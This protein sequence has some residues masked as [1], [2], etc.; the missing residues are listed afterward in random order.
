MK[1]SQIKETLFLET[2][3]GFIL[4]KS[5][6]IRVKSGMLDRTFP[7]LFAEWD[8]KNAFEILEIWSEGDVSFTGYLTLLSLLIVPFWISALVFL[9]LV[10]LQLKQ[11]N[12][13]YGIGL[14]SLMHL[15]SLQWMQ[16]IISILSISFLG[17]SGQFIDVAIAIVWFFML[18][19][20][21]VKQMV[22]WFAVRVFK[23]E[24]RQETFLY[25]V[26]M[27]EAIKRGIPVKSIE[28]MKIGL[29]EAIQKTK[30]N[31]SSKK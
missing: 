10:Y 13:L 29:E 26:C 6:W 27:K 19:I 12:I 8:R 17:N 18:R 23:L 7:G 9:G 1:F 5:G 4:P 15:F 2:P 11:R 22:E 28:E 30:R 25:W 14:H 20:G 3:Q 24:Q 16:V 31:P 21:T